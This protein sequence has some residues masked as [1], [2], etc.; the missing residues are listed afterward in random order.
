MHAAGG[1]AH[2]VLVFSLHHMPS[3]E[4][5]APA[6]G[7]QSAMGCARLFWMFS[8]ITMLGFGGVLPWM[9]RV[10]VEQRHVLSAQEF[11]ELFAL[12]QVLP[13]PSICNMAVMVG[14]RHAGVAGG[15]SALAGMMLGP[16]VLVILL[17]LGYEAHGHSPLLASVLA[18]MSAVA[19]GLIVVMALRMAVGLPR[20]WRS[21]LVA[22]LALLGIAVLHLALWLVLACLAPLGMVLLRGGRQDAGKRP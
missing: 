6:A 13:G 2:G 12:G 16:M 19:S 17:G 11:R 1:R 22:A 21:L 15:A 20:R 9:Y 4:P 8:H 14:Y 7:A 18:G 5:A 10:L 3:A